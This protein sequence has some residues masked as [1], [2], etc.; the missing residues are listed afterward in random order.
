MSGCTEKTFR[1]TTSCTNAENLDTQFSQCSYLLSN[2][3][4][5]LLNPGLFTVENRRQS[6]A[7]VYATESVSSCH[8]LLL[9]KVYHCPNF[10]EV[11]A[12]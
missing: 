10:A 4:N 3:A 1:R 2:V 8:R 12:D 5:I 9:G 6:L 7:I 11:R